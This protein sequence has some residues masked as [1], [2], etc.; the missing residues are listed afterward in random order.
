M[1]YFKGNPIKVRRLIP[2]SISSSRRRVKIRLVLKDGIEK[3]VLILTNIFYLFHSLSNLV[4]LGLL[5]DTE[6]F[7][8]NKDQTLYD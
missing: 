7:Y 5:N 1:T 4:S 6:I 3:L 2:E 8:H